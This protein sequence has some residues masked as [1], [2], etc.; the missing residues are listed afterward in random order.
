MWKI[1]P[2]VINS[3]NHAYLAVWVYLSV[4]HSGPKSTEE[5]LRQNQ[6]YFIGLARFHLDY[7]LQQSGC[8]TELP[9]PNY[10]D[11]LETRTLE[12]AISIID[13]DLT[14]F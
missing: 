7:T 10:S 14:E 5:V 12:V 1:M 11:F 6:G 13:S 2:F 8:E 9:L 3:N 4:L